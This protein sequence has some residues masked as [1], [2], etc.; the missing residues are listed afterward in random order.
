MNNRLENFLGTRDNN[1]NLIRIFAAALV[2][3]SHSFDLFGL[4]EP[5]GNL[6]GHTFGSVAVDVFFITSGLLIARSLYTRN[7]LPAFVKARVL[8]IY[9]ALIVAV[10][11][12]DSIS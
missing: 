9:P 6:L 7:N 11:F 3:Y 2:L 4:T 8:R 1:F 10:L 5:L 12:T